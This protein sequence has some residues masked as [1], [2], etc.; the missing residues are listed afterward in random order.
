[1]MGGMRE[2]VASKLYMA[3]N[4]WGPAEE[5]QKMKAFGTLGCVSK[6]PPVPQHLRV[7]RQKTLP[8]PYL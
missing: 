6:Y 4:R 8:P 1:M 2:L 3:Q 7:G 5:R